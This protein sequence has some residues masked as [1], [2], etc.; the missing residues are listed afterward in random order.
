MWCSGYSPQSLSPHN[1]KRS[2]WPTHLL[3]SYGLFVRIMSRSPHADSMTVMQTIVRTYWG[4]DLLGCGLI[5]VRTYWGADLLGCGL[6][7]VW[8]Y[9]HA[10]LLSCGLID[11]GEDLLGCRLIGVRTYWGAD[12]LSELFRWGMS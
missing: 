11:W 5:G 10:D 2:N 3:N 8:T 12:L 1:L 4:A 7:G 9:C 6:I